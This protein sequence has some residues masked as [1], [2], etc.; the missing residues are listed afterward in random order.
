MVDAAR[1][2][3]IADR[4]QRIVAEMLDRRIKDPRLG[5]VTVTDARITA[6]LRDATVYYTVFGT[7]DEKAASAAALESAKGVIRSEV[8]R[9]TGIRHTPSLAFVVD[10]VQE[11]A[12]HIEELLL[13]A[14]Q[15]DAELAE[16]ASGA[17]PAGEADPYRAPRED[18][19]DEDE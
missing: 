10:E 5:F 15:S 11:N 7:P 1:A 18:E 14:R 6:D 8:G 19:R 16:R 3:K 4:I 2:R 13:K 9:Q 12:Q 17:K